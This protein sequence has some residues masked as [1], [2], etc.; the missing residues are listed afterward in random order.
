MIVLDTTILSYAVGGDHELREA[1][2]DIVGMVR[3][4]QLAGTTTIE[5]IQEFTHVYSRRRPR[6]EAVEKARDYVRLLSPLL[7]T[8]TD[9]LLL[10]L[11]LYEA[12]GA[13]LGS[14]DAVLAAATMRSGARVLVSA[15]RKFTGL[16]GVR[17]FNPVDGVA[18]LLAFI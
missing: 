8:D 15:D 12:E 5:V 16:P 1:C 3:R 18:G 7:A 6:A 13:R 14:F 11:S 9:A 10:G 4:R 2:R 17:S